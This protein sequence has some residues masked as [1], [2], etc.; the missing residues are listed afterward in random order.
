MWRF[1]VTGPELRINLPSMTG[2]LTMVDSSI[3]GLYRGASGDEA[4]SLNEPHISGRITTIRHR[5]F[6]RNT[7]MVAISVGAAMTGFVWSIIEGTGLTPASLYFKSFL[8]LLAGGLLLTLVFAI[9]HGKPDRQKAKRS[10]IIYMAVI[11]IST[12]AAIG[13]NWWSST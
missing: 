12:F 2:D 6:I 13:I 1:G 9:Y 5:R 10:E 11:G 7:M 3:T 4:I 8:L